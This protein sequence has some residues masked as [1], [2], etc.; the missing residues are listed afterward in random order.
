M[1]N[2]SIEQVTTKE[3]PLEIRGHPITAV[4][5]D[6]GEYSTTLCVAAYVLNGEMRMAVGALTWDVKT[7]TIELITVAPMFRHKGIATSLWKAA[8]YLEPELK[9]SGHRSPNGDGW[10][11]NLGE[12]TPKLSKKLAQKEADQRGAGLMVTLG[13]L[14]KDALEAFG[15]L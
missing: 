3:S 7:K 10:V 14:D 8:K 4:K 1:N 6:L 12:D 11:K 13:G 5:V 9:H 15:T 2:V